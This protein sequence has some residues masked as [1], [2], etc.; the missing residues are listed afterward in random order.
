MDH[1]T[2]EPK[3]QLTSGTSE[4]CRSV[5]GLGCLT[6][7]DI[8]MKKDVKVFTAIQDGIDRAN[9]KAVSRAQLIRKWVILP[10]DFSIA[11]GELGELTISIAFAYIS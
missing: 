8:L 7:T 11:G 3:D 2:L 10:H 5:G 4:W 1:E 9:R 6:V